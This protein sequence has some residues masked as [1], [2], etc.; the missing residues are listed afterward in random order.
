MGTQPCADLHRPVFGTQALLK[1]VNLSTF[2]MEA[3][4]RQR[5]VGLCHPE[6]SSNACVRQLNR[7]N[8]C[9]RQLYPLIKEIN[10][11][12]QEIDVHFRHTRQSFPHGSFSVPR[13]EVRLLQPKAT[14]GVD[15]DAPCGANRILPLKKLC[16]NAKKIVDS[17]VKAPV[18]PNNLRTPAQEGLGALTELNI[19]SQGGR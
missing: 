14:E 2:P 11:L 13:G 8:A 4:V 19:F 7:G 17:S 10:C 12:N 5:P 18:R 6:S 15:L 9:V 1:R 16:A 3:K